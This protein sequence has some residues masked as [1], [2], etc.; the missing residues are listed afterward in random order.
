MQNNHDR[1]LYDKTMRD[2]PRVLIHPRVL[3]KRPWLDEHELV[4]CWHNAW[5]RHT[6]HD[7][8]PVQIIAVGW[9]FHDR[10]IEM[11][12]YYSA[13]QFAWVILHANTAQKKILRELGLTTNDIRSIR[14]RR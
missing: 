11:I 3:A 8:D 14:G 12:A 13:R 2:Q 4:Q 7:K 9:D 1:L 5:R 10:C 6:R